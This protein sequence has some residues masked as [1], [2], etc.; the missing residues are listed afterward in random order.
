MK[1]LIIGPKKCTVQRMRLLFVESEWTDEI[2]GEVGYLKT[3]KAWVGG[4][5]DSE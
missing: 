4:F 2:F 1:G 3:T 5:A